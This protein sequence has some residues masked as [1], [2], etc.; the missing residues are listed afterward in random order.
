[1]SIDIKTRLTFAS[2]T[3]GTDSTETPLILLTIAGSSNQTMVKDTEPVPIGS[4]TSREIPSR[5]SSISSQ[6]YAHESSLRIHS[7][8]QTL[9][10]VGR[11]PRRCCNIDESQ[12]AFKE[13]ALSILQKRKPKKTPQ[14]VHFPPDYS[15][16]SQDCLAKCRL[17]PYS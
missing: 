6:D 16:A 10:A 7:T 5:I 12:S 9:T 2:Q 13:Q 17:N 1:M 3:G 15:S 4:R 8:T 11:I 14:L